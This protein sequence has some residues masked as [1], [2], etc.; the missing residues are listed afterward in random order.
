MV[1]DCLASAI[2]RD[3]IKYHGAFQMNWLDIAIVIVLGVLTF[4]GL[5][6]GLV[7]CIVPLAGII[8]GIIL[9]MEMMV[10]IQIMMN[11]EMR[12]ALDTWLRT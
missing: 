5:K 7:N 2:W 11:K 10:I 9:L 3:M 4:W 6:R 8:L 12:E 1:S